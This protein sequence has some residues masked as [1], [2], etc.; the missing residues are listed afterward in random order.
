[1]TKLLSKPHNLTGFDRLLDQKPKNQMFKVASSRS[2][3]MGSSLIELL[4]ATALALFAA[5]TAAQLINS[6]NT[7]GLNRRAAATSAIEVAISNDLAWFRQ[8]A[9]LWQLE[10]GPYETLP[11]VVTQ[12]D[13]EQIPS[14]NPSNLSNKYKE[15]SGCSTSALANAFQKDA[16]KL[17]TDFDAIKKPPYD[18]PNGASTTTFDLPK[19]ASGYMLERRIQPNDKVSGTLTITYTLSKSGTNIFERSSSVYLPAAGW[20]T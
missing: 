14:P 1:M 4:L 9:V 19:S 8:Y 12:T 13:Y 18:I 2:K 10:R 16:A 7:S 15:P 6:L 17:K 5:S 3:A 20:C 11:K